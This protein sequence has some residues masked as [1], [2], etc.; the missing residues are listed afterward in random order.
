[1]RFNKSNDHIGPILHTF[2]RRPGTRR[3]TPAER[4]R[5][6]PH[7][8]FAHLLCVVGTALAMFMASAGTARAEGRIRISEQFGIVYVLLNIIHDQKLIEKYGKAEGLDIKV[9]WIRLS[10][11]NAVNTALLSGA[12]DIGA[13]GIGPLL[14]IWD[15][16]YGKQDIRGIASLGEFPNYLVSN[17]P[18][19]KTIADF[20]AK[21]RIALPAVGVSVQARFLQMAAA[22]KWGIKHYNKLDG[23][24]V[25]LPHPD[26]TAAII[27]G[28]T[29]IRAHFGNPPF[30]EEELA[31]NPNAHIV[32]KSYDVMGGPVSSTVLFATRKF[33]EENPK[34]YKAFVEALA[35]AAA[36]ARA[37]PDSA[38][39]AYLRVTGSK[40]D[41]AFLVKLMKSPDIRFKI[42]PR[43]TYQIARFMHRIGAI[44]HLPQSWK[45]YF[46]ADP[47]TAQGS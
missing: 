20:T 42:A 18:K 36:F 44:R 25:A 1:M 24:T 12:I 16:A 6:S 37:H 41:R 38:A 19:V 32:L 39:D 47:L 13:A 28:G 46:F 34:T 35:Q 9:D 3:Q 22:K 17:N 29:E 31:R 8:P 2:R 45:D 4:P 15:R 26:A 21:D 43:N 30:Q 7:R 14:T 11:G 23:I 33:R 5:T 27:S 40:I 10:G